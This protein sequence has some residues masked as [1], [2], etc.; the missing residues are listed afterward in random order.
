MAVTDDM[1]GRVQR[2]VALWPGNLQGA[3]WIAIAGLVLTIMTALIKT[4]GDTIPVI[5]IL[6][7]RQMVMTATMMPGILRNP[8]RAFATDTPGLHLLRIVLSSIA[9]TTGFT[10]MVHLPLADAVAISFSRSF[11]VAIFA[12]LLLHEIVGRHRWA[13]IAAGFVGVIIITD[14]TGAEIDRYVLL[15]LLSAAAVALIMVI[16][17][18]LAQRE[19]LPTV[20]TYQAVGVGLILAVPTYLIW[21][22]PTPMEWILLICIG[23][24]STLGQSLNF[25]AFRVGEATALAPVDYLR[26]IYSTAIGAVFFLEQPTWSTMIGALLVILG[27]FWGLWHER[28]GAHD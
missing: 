14:P 18:K 7:L 24:L 2:R 20:I 16:V 25:M 15:A 27:T 8:R 22:P 11:F 26:L 5:Q 12:I 13:G 17:R 23:L 9:M 4:V 6:F 21:V 28:H 1:M 10:A 3:L 19:R